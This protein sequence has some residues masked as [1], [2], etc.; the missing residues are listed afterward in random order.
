[1]AK[2]EALYVEIGQRLRAIREVLS[3]LTQ[4]EWAEKHG[5]GKTQYNNW[6]SG[7]RR[8]TVDEAE[9]LCHVYGLTLDFIYR[10]I[11][12]RL[13]ENLRNSL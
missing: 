8:I 9:R 1:M 12:D 10:G 7:A 13:P 3:D 5:F 2:E 4:K 6:E 11:K